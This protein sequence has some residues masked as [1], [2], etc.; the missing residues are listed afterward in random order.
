MGIFHIAMT[1]CYRRLHFYV[2]WWLLL[3]YSGSEKFISQP[4]LQPI[5]LLIVNATIHFN[6]IPNRQLNET[7]VYTVLLKTHINVL[8]DQWVV[9]IA[10]VNFV[11]LLSIFNKLIWSYFMR[12]FAINCFQ[13]MKQCVISAMS[14]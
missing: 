7:M 5:L 2:D 14:D 13:S 9:Q 12:K 4:L 1:F 6:E 3:P 10:T 11:V 8:S